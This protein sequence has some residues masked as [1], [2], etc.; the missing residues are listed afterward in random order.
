MP[1]E[2]MLCWFA[3]LERRP[4]GWR[5]DLRTSYLLQ[6]Q[7]SKQ[8][9]SDIFPSLAAVTQGQSDNPMSSFKKSGFF[10]K[11]SQAVGG[12]KLS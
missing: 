10:A 5:E 6:A 9:P 4:I 12:D 2:E 7:G 8:K 3:Y 1:Y 11:I